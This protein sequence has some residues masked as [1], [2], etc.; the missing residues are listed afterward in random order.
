MSVSDVV[1]DPQTVIV[2]VDPSQRKNPRNT[3]ERISQDTVNDTD[4]KPVA[5]SSMTAATSEV[6]TAPVLSVARAVIV[7]RPTGSRG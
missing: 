4:G 2:A 7:W 1:L 3:L 5:P 6:C